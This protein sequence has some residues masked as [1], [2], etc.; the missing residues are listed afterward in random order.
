MSR[1][2][3]LFKEIPKEFFAEYPDIIEILKIYSSFEENGIEKID[4]DKYILTKENLEYF[5]KSIK[6]IVEKMILTYKR[7]IRDSKTN[8]YNMRFFEETLKLEIKECLRKKSKIS[9]I[10][11]DI[12]FF[13]KINDSYGHLVG[14]EI[15]LEL[16]NLLLKKIRDM[17]IVARFGGE[18]FIILVKDNLTI[19]KKI[20]KRI[21]EEVNLNNLLKK[22]NLKISGGITEI[23]DSDKVPSDII[24]RAD[25]ALY[26]AKEAGRDKFISI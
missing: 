1:L 5:D 26:M 15:L 12:D 3:K 10:I 11:I 7:S 6:E 24:S 20:V 2:E 13:K 4:E 9:L 18:E 23:K 16:S 21:Q 14:D 8:L 22:Y 17:D 25:K 19:A